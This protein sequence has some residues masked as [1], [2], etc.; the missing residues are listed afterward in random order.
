MRSEY[1]CAS[2]VLNFLAFGAAQEVYDE[3]ISCTFALSLQGTYSCRLP[4]LN[5]ADDEKQELTFDVSG[6]L[7]DL[8]NENV[9]NVEIYGGNVPFIIT[10]IFQNFPN[11]R[12]MT[13]S[14]AGL[15]RI[16]TKAFSN[17]VNLLTFVAYE[18]S[19]SSIEPYAFTGALS[20]NLINLYQNRIQNIHESAFYG[21]YS[22][23]FL[24]LG[25]NNLSQLPQNL[26]DSQKS[27]THLSVQFNHL[28]TLDGRIFSNNLLL[29]DISFF[30][31]QIN[32]TGRGLVDGLN[33]L[34]YFDM[35]LNQCVD[36]QWT[37][38]GSVTL[39]TVIEGLEECVAN[40][41]V[42]QPIDEVRNLT[43]ELRGSLVIR[44]EKGNEILR[45]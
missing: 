31:N 20:L 42:E 12:S 2:L 40:Y 14:Y 11:V 22:L 10:Q 21:V 30:G 38:F 32:S 13:I 45:L 35:R 28:E 23:M 3:T 19:I 25:S 36:S 44:D 5:I 4:S 24:N 34:M 39:K 17:A 6:H 41:P 26:F 9:T 8:G 37:L 27:L 15:S 33:D 18:N 7:D 16:Q 43:L 29:Q 1:F